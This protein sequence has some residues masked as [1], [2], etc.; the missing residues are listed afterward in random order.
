MS[1]NCLC[2][3]MPSLLIAH[4]AAFLSFPALFPLRNHQVRVPPHLV[5]C[6]HS[7]TQKYH[8]RTVA[9]MN[10][11]FHTVKECTIII[12]GSWHILHTYFVDWFTITYVHFLL[13]FAR[14]QLSR[15]TFLWSRTS[16]NSLKIQHSS[17]IN[18][19][20]SLK[21][22]ACWGS[23]RGSLKKSLPRFFY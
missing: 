21:H 15:S 1:S 12:L 2:S 13:L 20:P 11:V 16:F 18:F 6:S 14:F 22:L 7:E 4:L 9:L 5:L 17:R 10:P 19:Y 8:H 23:D 3:S